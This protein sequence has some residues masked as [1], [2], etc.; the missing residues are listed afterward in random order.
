MDV[1]AKHKIEQPMTLKEYPTNM[2]LAIMERAEFRI[3]VNSDVN[4]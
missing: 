2:R 3:E 4:K 1:M